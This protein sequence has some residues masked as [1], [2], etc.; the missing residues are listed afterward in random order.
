MDWIERL[1]HIVPDGGD[2]SLELLCC[3][4]AAL[5]I[6]AFLFRRHVADYALALRSTLFLK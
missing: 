6:A 5:V 4:S 3:F 1:T 2:G